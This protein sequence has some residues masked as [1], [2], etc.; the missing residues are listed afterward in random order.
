[1]SVQ[2]TT[3]VSNPDLVAALMS[4]DVTRVG[5][6]LSAG[7][8]R[9]LLPA[10]DLGD[11][12][13]IAHAG[14]DGEG[15]RL[16]WAFT[17]SEALAAFDRRPATA[18]LVISGLDLVRTP[19]MVAL[20]PAGPGAT[21]IQGGA[22]EAAPGLAPAGPPT[23]GASSASEDGLVQPDGRAEMR[24]RA[25]DAHERGRAAAA[26][27]DL[28]EAS[29]QFEQ[30]LAAC[31]RLGDR[32]HGGATA[33]DLAACQV[34]RGDADLALA[35]WERAADVLSRFGETDLALGAL[36]DAAEVAVT[37]GELDEADRLGGEALRLA[38]GAE[39][40]DRI[41]AIWRAVA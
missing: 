12:R 26:A 21:M 33:L 16:I 15:R 25:R 1:M 13:A 27:G 32:L 36:L 4:G 14:R 22:S 2:D 39:A 30:A 24:R 34:R 5:E 3:P 41:A 9:L 18:T 11:G 31:G 19:E 8:T 35:L 28:Q 40:A 6:A 23:N 29:A 10:S 17:D 37:A 7:T 38:A 20:N